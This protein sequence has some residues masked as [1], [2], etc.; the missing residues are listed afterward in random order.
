MGFQK[1]AMNVFGEHFVIE[2]FID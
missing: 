2:K 1:L